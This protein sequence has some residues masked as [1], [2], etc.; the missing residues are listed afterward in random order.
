MNLCSWELLGS[1][2]SAPTCVCTQWCPRREQHAGS[3]KASIVFLCGSLAGVLWLLLAGWAPW[4]EEWEFVSQAIKDL[5]KMVNKPAPRHKL[6]WRA[7]TTPFSSGPWRAIQDKT[8]THQPGT[9]ATF[10]FDILIDYWKV[11]FLKNCYFNKRGQ[12]LLYSSG[13]LLTNCC[14]GFSF[15]I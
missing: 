3:G 6:D 9:I 11:F 2:A 7:H 8:V 10:P 12:S 15:F 14:V 4:A 5:A 13:Y 1:S